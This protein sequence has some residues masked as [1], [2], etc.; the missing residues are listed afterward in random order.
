MK[1]T[2]NEGSYLNCHSNEHTYGCRASNILIKEFYSKN[3]HINFEQANISL[4]NL[5]NMSMSIDIDMDSK[6]INQYYE[7][8]ENTTYNSIHS[9]EVEYLYNFEFILNKIKLTQLYQYD[10]LVTA[11]DVE[12]NRPAPDMI[13]YAMNLFSI[14][15]AQEIVKVGDSK[16]DIEEGKNANCLYSIGITTGAQTNAQLLEA[17][18]DAIINDLN[19]FLTFLKI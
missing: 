18:P 14:K 2:Q 5:F 15:D 4:I 1:K 19:E 17:K 13:H 12:K 8:K 16:I 11:S 9:T 7:E 10:L 6:N 3:K